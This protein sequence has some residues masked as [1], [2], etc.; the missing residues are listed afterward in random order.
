MNR[1]YIIKRKIL[2]LIYIFNLFI[3]INA[4]DTLINFHKRIK[5]ASK[6]KKISNNKMT[7]SYN[8]ISGIYCLANDFIKKGSYLYDIPKSLTI[9]P[10]YLFPYKFEIMDI[11]LKLNTIQNSLEKDQKLATYLL[12]FQYLIYRYPAKISL[13]KS[14]EINKF[15]D[16]YNY[17]EPDNSIFD[18]YP[19]FV[20][21]L[22]NSDEENIYILKQMKISH[23]QINELKE[24][25][26][27]CFFEISKEQKLMELIFIIKDFKTFKEAYALIMSRSMTIALKDYLILE[28]LDK[29]NKNTTSASVSY[30]N[31]DS[32]SIPISIKKNNQRNLVIGRNGSPA[33]ISFIELCNHGQPKFFNEKNK[34]KEINNNNNR[35][36]IHISI[37]KGSY[38]HKSSNFYRPGEEIVFNYLHNPTS[39]Y[40]SLNYGFIL[41]KNIFDIYLIKIKD[42]A[43]IN[44]NQE[45]LCKILDCSSSVNLSNNGL[46]ENLLNYGR[47]KFFRKNILDEEILNKL[48]KDKIFF[49]SNENEI[50]SYIHYFNILK[51]ELMIEHKNIMECFS[52]GTGVK[53]ALKIIEENHNLK[54]EKLKLKIL[55]KWK[56]LKLKETIYD[57]AFLSKNILI[58]NTEKIL[59]NI[60]KINSQEII[61]IKENYLK[62]NFNLEK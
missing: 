56:K 32:D 37:K 14:I 9:N 48:N 12:V 57:L 50:A 54:K 52:G 47:I 8:K 55:N 35:N 26:D 2:L 45:N 22:Y 15:F 23:Y 49:F 29:S 46:N 16:Y 61:N 33:L 43:L 39:F 20:S 58:I 3:S 13:K 28:G 53:L 10:Y 60:I 24:I 19:N 41:K 31:S 17:F 27:Y 7:F 62:E 18:S 4:I 42:F 1:I 38:V 21:S 5:F 30:S 44:K 34:N 40:L 59:N 25:Y 11:L 6:L 51:F 36:F